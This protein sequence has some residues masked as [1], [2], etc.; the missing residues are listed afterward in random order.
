MLERVYDTG[1][2]PAW[3]TRALSGTV[4]LLLVHFDSNLCLRYSGR[5]LYYSFAIIDGM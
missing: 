1:A 5:T 4:L 2:L 3:Y